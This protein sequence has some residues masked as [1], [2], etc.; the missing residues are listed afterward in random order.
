MDDINLMCIFDHLEFTD[1]LAV[2]ELNPRFKQLIETHYMLPKYHIDDK[3]IRFAQSPSHVETDEITIFA[4]NHIQRLLTNYGHLI[5]KIVFSGIFFNITEVEMINQNIVQYCSKSLV[6][7][8]L[9]D[10]GTHLLSD[11]TTIFDNVT[12]INLR[13]YQSTKLQLQRIYPKLAKLTLTVGE[14]FIL[15]IIDESYSNLMH[16]VFMEFADFTN[17]SYLINLIQLNPQI[18]HLHLNRMPTI[19]FAHLIQANLEHLQTLQVAYNPVGV[20]EWYAQHNQSI[21]FK[22]VKHLIV[23]IQ[24]SGHSFHRFPMTFEK[25]EVLDIDLMSFYHVPIGLI[26]QNPHL[27]MLSIPLRF[28]INRQTILNCIYDLRE[29]NEMKTNWGSEIRADVIRLMTELRHLTR[30]TFYVLDGEK[31]NLLGSISDEWRMVNLLKYNFNHF[32]VTFERVVMDCN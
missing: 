23:S 22:T 20:I 28:V 11:A 12:A 3:L 30:I 32:F 1:L 21:H 8:R 6:E 9:I 31:D 29:L 19:D 18:R 17:D 13:L 10:A 27:K 15:P 5:R 14:T 24:H 25:L 4:S 16:L 7:L 26:Q 2:S